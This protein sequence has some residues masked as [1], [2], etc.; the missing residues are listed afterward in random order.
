[1]GAKVGFKN[2]VAGH[3]NCSAG[4]FSCFITHWNCSDG[5]QNCCQAPK[6]CLSV[7]KSIHV[8]CTPNLLCRIPKLFCC[9]TKLL[10]HA[11]KLPANKNSSK[12]MK[13]RSS[14]ESLVMGILVVK[15]NCNSTAR[16]KSYNFLKNNTWYQLAYYSFDKWM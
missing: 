10:C 11:S 7:L 8:R 15:M 3:Q 1:L 9:T 16:F 5:H 6:L 12:H 14:F 2:G 4:H 13:M